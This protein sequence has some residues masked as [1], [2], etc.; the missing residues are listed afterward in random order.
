[1]PM[2][3]SLPT[4]LM[5]ASHIAKTPDPTLKTAFRRN[6]R[7]ILGDPADFLADRCIPVPVG[8]ASYVLVS[9]P[10]DRNCNRTE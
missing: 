1:M 9:I 2:G 10:M 7:S 5:L 4:H 8:S 6:L 3:K